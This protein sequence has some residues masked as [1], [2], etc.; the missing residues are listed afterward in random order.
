MDI[1]LIGKTLLSDL[2][3]WM[4]VAVSEHRACEKD[5][6][7]LLGYDK[8]SICRGVGDLVDAGLMRKE[9]EKN[10]KYLSLTDRIGVERCGCKVTITA[11][12]GADSA[13]IWQFLLSE[14]EAEAFDQF[15]PHS[16]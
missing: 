8:T 14:S 3:R 13:I 15:V 6:V 11:R 12:P 16:E 10:C 9:R 1:G 7:K 2:R 5:L 4:L